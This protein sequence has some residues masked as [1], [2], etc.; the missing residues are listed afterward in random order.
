MVGAI[1]PP[2]LMP[3]PDKEEN[4]APFTKPESSDGEIWRTL[5]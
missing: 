5:I 2:I 3:V 4:V 1:F